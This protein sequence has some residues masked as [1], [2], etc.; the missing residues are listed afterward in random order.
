MSEN[1][2]HRHIKSYMRN[3][4]A[5]N[6]SN[7]DCLTRRELLR[8]GAVSLLGAGLL[9]SRSDA[10]AASRFVRAGRA[11]RC[12]VLNLTGGMSH[13]DTWD[14]KPDAPRAMRGP[15]QPIQT[16]VPGMEICEI[17][18]RMARHAD[19]FAIVRS[20][21]NV[22][23]PT[24]EASRQNDQNR[25]ASAIGACSDAFG[26]H[27]FGA[28]VFSPYS[29]AHSL[30]SQDCG[31]IPV[32]VTLPCTSSASMPGSLCGAS[33]P[34]TAA[35]SLAGERDQVRDR[36]GRNG[37]GQA[38]LRSRRLVERGARFVSVE[39]YPNGYDGPTWDAHGSA[40]FSDLTAYRTHC[41]PEFDNA[42]ISLIEDLQA[43]GLYDSTI[44]LATG[45]W[46][47][48]PLINRHGGRARWPH[49]WSLLIGGGGLRG[50]Q[51]IGASDD[52]GGYPVERPVT[53]ANIAATLRRA[54][55]PLP[56][57][58]SA[59]H[60]NIGPRQ[61]SAQTANAAQPLRELL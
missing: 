60:A 51:V 19:K 53:P 22:P 31:H 35:L 57:S 23:L 43:R 7:A 39:M 34:L 2:Q 20:M 29:P 3:T 61:P 14:M 55:D 4:P 50:G 26:I 1:G 48:A 52:L 49:C 33:S 12:I 10:E 8:A 41:G 32:S 21:H 13:L 37:F 40:P 44:V 47:R 54:L 38:C 24:A 11:V 45:A 56:C 6:L 28:D 25:P 59:N 58:Q 9:G 16:N 30:T 5:Y 46:G 36:Y 17:F 15:F 18:P 42:Y 27:A